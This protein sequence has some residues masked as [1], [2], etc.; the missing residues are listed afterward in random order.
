MVVEVGGGAALKTALRSPNGAGLYSVG[1]LCAT[2]AAAVTGTGAGTDAAGALIVGNADGNADFGATDAD[3]GKRV[4][5]KTFGDVLREPNTDVAVF[6]S[7]GAEDVR[8]ANGFEGGLKAEGSAAVVVRLSPKTDLAGGAPNGDTP[9]VMGGM[10]CVTGSSSSGS[11]SSSSS[12]A[13][14][15][16]SSACFSSPTSTI[17]SVPSI[18]SGTVRFPRRPSMSSKYP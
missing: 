12:Y 7:L 14:S 5:P 1:G 3:V 8:E 2:G 13:S 18:I 9:F 6:E 15:A 16:P 4:F 10:G 11:S 17:L